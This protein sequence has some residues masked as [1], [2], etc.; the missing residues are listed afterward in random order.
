MSQCY[1]MQIEVSGH[2]PEKEDEI[3]RAA[4][5]EWPFSDWDTRGDCL[6]AEGYGQLCESVEQF[7]TR[8]TV[9][10]WKANGSFCMVAVYS[11]Y[12]EALPYEAFGLTA[13]DYER[14]V[15]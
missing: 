1:N 6:R 8:L 7:V 5:K 2:L 11:T 9:A 3:S 12:L 14:L 13:Q 4:Q 10:V 15:K